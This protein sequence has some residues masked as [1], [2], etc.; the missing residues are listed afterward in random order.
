MTNGELLLEYELATMKYIVAVEK[1]NDEALEK[2][3]KYLC[4]LKAEI[5]ERMK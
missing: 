4:K 1:K 3:E 2:Y 5:L